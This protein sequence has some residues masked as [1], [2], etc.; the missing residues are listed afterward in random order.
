[1]RA[2]IADIK[3]NG[4]KEAIEVVEHNAQKYIVNGHHRYYAAMKLGIENVPIK[5]VDLP[6]LGYQTVSDLIPRFRLPG[7]WKY[8]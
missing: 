8:L 1:M 4:I 6:H 5:I 2:L 3:E 7:F